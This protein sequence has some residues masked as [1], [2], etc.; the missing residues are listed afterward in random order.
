MS[1]KEAIYL[2]NGASI[3]NPLLLSQVNYYHLSHPVDNPSLISLLVVFLRK[4]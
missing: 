4:Q 3:V 2:G 1:I